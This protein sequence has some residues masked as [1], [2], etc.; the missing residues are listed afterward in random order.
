MP[1]PDDIFRGVDARYYINP[2]NAFDLST[3]YGRDNAPGQLL[4][5][6][7]LDAG[8]AG[9]KGWISWLPFVIFLMMLLTMAIWP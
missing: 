7:G 3:P 9:T 6:D 2:Y 1:E 5:D 4:R 8:E